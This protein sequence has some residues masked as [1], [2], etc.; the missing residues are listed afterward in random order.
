MKSL[1]PTRSSRLRL[2]AALGLAAAMLVS[3][4]APSQAATTAPVLFDLKTLAPFVHPSEHPGVTRT[5][6][7]RTGADPLVINAV[8]IDPAQASDDQLMLKGAIGIWSR[9]VPLGGTTGMATSET[10]KSLLEGTTSTAGRR[11]Y[12]GVNA[13]YFDG[14]S[15]DPATGRK[16]GD[17]NGVSVQN[18]KL[19]S[20]AVRGKGGRP[21]G[22]VLVLDAGRP[23]ITDLSTDLKIGWYDKDGKLT[24]RELDGINR[25][26]GRASH[27]E[28]PEEGEIQRGGICADDSEIIAF[29]PEWGGPTP[30]NGWYANDAKDK[31]P[32]SNLQVS[33]DPGIEVVIDENGKLKECYD[34][35]IP[36]ARAAVTPC[37]ERPAGR[38]GQTVAPG[39]QVLQ[40]IGEGARWLRE[41]LTNASTSFDL[42]QTVKDER[43]G[44]VLKLN[45]SMFV[46]PGGERL[47][48]NG[49]FP[50]EL[51]P[52]TEGCPG[53][54]T[55]CRPRTA[56]GVD[57]EGR[58]ILVT[59]DGD[60]PTH[61]V[62]MRR[63]HLAELMKQLGAVE[64][65]N[66]D[67]GGSTT[68]VWEGNVANRPSDEGGT[69]ERAVG[70]ALF[71]GV[72][73]YP[74][75]I[76]PTP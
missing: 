46:A 70:D 34:A 23:Y 65:L 29:T 42:T 60:V 52:A 56:A 68:L 35:F 41:R 59:V 5:T 6:Y 63:R 54:G 74:M 3:P 39:T 33:T 61:S 53:T 67:G 17:I 24:Q 10:V 7:S 36:T 64:A 22:T 28:R 37:K 40:G 47:V 1:A 48:E 26:P 62:G 31:A 43:Y 73:A 55:D 11:P 25:L 32:A 75:S 50:A 9:A 57:A 30:T 58:L 38:G 2:G 45:Q 12:F 18:G 51:T 71:A 69:Q 72:G 13:G 15:V 49:D 21:H 16:E 76:N 14:H 19:V 4:T 66:M 20:E 27:C 44:D 8:V